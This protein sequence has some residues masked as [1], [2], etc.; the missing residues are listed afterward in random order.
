MSSPSDTI[1]SATS[2]E[3]LELIEP[4]KVGIPGEKPKVEILPYQRFIVTQ[5]WI[6]QQQITKM[7]EGN[8]FFSAGFLGL[9]MFMMPV[10]SKNYHLL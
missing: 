7:I 6:K 2:D 3:T 4:S 8:L 10:I 9:A 5:L 1:Q